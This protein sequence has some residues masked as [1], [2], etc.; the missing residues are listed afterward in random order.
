MALDATH[1]PQT[2]QTGA[3]LEGRMARSLLVSVNGDRLMAIMKL[4]MRAV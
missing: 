3:R 1:R 4:Y 2:A